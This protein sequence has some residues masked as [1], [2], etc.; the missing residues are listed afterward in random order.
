VVDF[1]LYRLAFA[2]ALIAI[3]ALMFS[4]DG[5]PASLDPAVPP[6]S[7]EER[8]AAALA[9]QI[10]ETAPERTPGSDGDAAA[11]ELVAE[12]FEEVRAGTVAEQE[13]E[14]K[15][16]GD[17][18]VLRNVVITLP[19]ETDEAIVVLAARDSARGPGAASS[20]AATGA[21]AELAAALGTT[22]HQKTFVLASTSGAS[23]GAAG[24]RKLIE[25]L[26]DPDAV[27]AVVVIAQ[28][29]ASEPA[30]PFAIESSTGANRTSAQL[31][32]TAESAVQ[33]QAQ[34]GPGSPGAFAQLA[35]LAVPSG[36][37]EQA[38]LIDEGIE[39]VA[40]SSA[41]ERP[42]P[43]SRDTVEALSMETL[44]EFARAVHSVVQAI[45][46][47]P[48][49]LA[50]GSDTYVEVGDN[51]V[52]GW[53]LSLLALALLL[54]PLLAAIDAAARCRRWSE[55]LPSGLAWA[56]TRPLPLVGGLAALYLL[57]L[58]GLVPRPEF[59]FDPGRFSVGVRA[60]LVIVVLSAVVGTTARALRVGSR[61]RGVSRA[62]LVAS[63]GLVSSAAG[64]LAWFA[65]PYLGLLAAPAASA[66]LLAAG[67]RGAGPP[68]IAI[69]GV[70]GAALLA[71]L[72]LAFI[73]VS[74][75]LD[76]GGGTP[77]ILLLLV[78][79]GQIG[80]LAALSLCFLFPAVAATAIACGREPDVDTRPMARRL[81]PDDLVHEVEIRGRGGEKSEGG[82]D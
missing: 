35:R 41:G 39:A 18:V 64:L 61:P 38:P 81:R 12:R 58:I 82:S 15:Y 73:E 32:A 71:P 57:A 75:A 51:L 37:G 63:L 48:E 14:S 19:G 70:G 16:D 25:G 31:V 2:P 6:G 72:A 45:D 42:L 22:G 11:A 40:I 80:L 28:P 77:W 60:V 27:E 34:R 62:A 43:P 24:A 49:P 52:P 55:P 26:P 66:W 33:T 74:A 79:D 46:A 7:F 44:G 69:A 30:P 8:R 13:V 67:D 59:P 54:P 5:V 3:V 36:L 76:L 29:G 78:A 56:A 65:N 68:R 17:D 23:G 53:T 50:H 10:V 9:R 47:A 4:L 21:L 20:A 1:R